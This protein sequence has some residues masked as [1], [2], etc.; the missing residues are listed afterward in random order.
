M[1]GH[2]AEGDLCTL[3]RGATSDTV[4]SQLEFYLEDNENRVGLH[5]LMSLGHK[6]LMESFREVFHPQ[7]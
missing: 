2:G 4:S 5:P 7:H 3:R 1:E 6:S